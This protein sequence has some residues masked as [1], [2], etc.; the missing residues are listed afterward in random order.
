MALVVA[1]VLVGMMFTFELA[2]INQQARMTFFNYT[3]D[4]ALDLNYYVTKSLFNKIRNKFINPQN[5]SKIDNLY[6]QVPPETLKELN[7]DLPQSGRNKYFNG[8]TLMV[9]NGQPIPIEFKLR[10]DIDHHWRYLKQSFR[11]RTLVAQNEDAFYGKDQLELISPKGYYMLGEHFTS[12]IGAKLGL[13]VPDHRY[14]NFF[15]NNEFMGVFQ[16]STPIDQ[17]SFLTDKNLPLGSIFEAE[18]IS[19]SYKPGI[20]SST[21]QA[22][23]AWENKIVH[24]QEDEQFQ[25]LIDLMLAVNSKNLAKVYEL[26]D[27]DYFINLEVLVYF[28]QITHWDNRHNVKLYYNP[29][30]QKFQQIP[31]DASFLVNQVTTDTFIPNLNLA[32]NDF[33][34]LLLSD[35]KFINDKNY[36]IYQNV[37]AGLANDIIAETN[38]MHDLLQESVKRDYYWYYRNIWISYQDWVAY[39]DN[40]KKMIKKLEQ[41]F[42]ADIDSPKNICL[43]QLED[44]VKISVKGPAAL[45]LKQLTF[46]TNQKNSQREFS[47][48]ILYPGISRLS[49]SYPLSTDG[50]LISGTFINTFS[51]SEYTVLAAKKAKCSQKL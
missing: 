47:N 2:Y 41:P 36:V 22:P 1:F 8:A 21:F 23:F 18:N 3:E 20:G 12:Y 46:T 7:A 40:F 43:Q 32:S 6:F 5:L 16:A 27:Y 24:D 13:I 17:N 26:I 10:G 30:I 38:K 44:E 33:Y 9:N 4:N 35:P 11:F 51:G 49:Y 34:K 25:K 42:L 48:E 39:L 15:I 37:Q 19:F 29:T 50:K 31:W 45:S 14:V 28:G